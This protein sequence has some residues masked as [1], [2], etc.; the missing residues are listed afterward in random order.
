MDAIERAADIESLQEIDLFERLDEVLAQQAARMRAT[1]WDT[2]WPDRA[3]NT[4]PNT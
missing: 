3:S 2:C 4:P 1:Y